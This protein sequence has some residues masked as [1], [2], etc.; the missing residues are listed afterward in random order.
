MNIRT[1][2]GQILEALP[3]FS[4]VILRGARQTG[5]TTLTKQLAEETILSAGVAP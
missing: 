5:K 1:L 2:T 3:D 4:A